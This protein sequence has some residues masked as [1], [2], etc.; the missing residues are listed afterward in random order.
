MTGLSQLS[1]LFPNAASLSKGT[2]T[3]LFGGYDPANKLPYTN[4]WTIDLQWQP[5][6]TSERQ[7][8]LRRQP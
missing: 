5:V 4:N 8:G 7:P 1:N 3:Y 2:T 6:N